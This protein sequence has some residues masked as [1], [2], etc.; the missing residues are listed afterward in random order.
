M[1]VT[2]YA[3]GV[4]LLE[5]SVQNYDWGSFHEIPA[6]L[7]DAP[8]GEPVAELWLGTHRLGPSSVVEPD[9]SSRLLSEVA[10]ELPFML[11]VLSARR[12]LSLQVHPGLELAR[13]GFE[14]ENAAGVPVNAPERSFRDPNHKPEM[15]YALSTFDMMAGFRPTAEILRVL[16]PIETSLARRLRERLTAEP[17]FAGIV[18]LVEWLVT[19]RPS[20]DEIEALSRACRDLLDQGVDIKRAYATALL[21]REEFPNDA[22]VVVALLMNRLTLQPGEAAFLGAGMLHAHLKGLCLEAMASSDNVLRAGL[23]TKH[24]DAEALV[25][26]LDDGMSRLARVTPVVTPAGVE[27]FD[28]AAGEFALSVAQT[29]AA[30]TGGVELFGDGHR[31][32]ICSAGEVACVNAR[33]E[34]VKLR[35]GQSLYAGPDDGALTVQGTGE[36]AQAFVPTSGQTN[37]LIDLI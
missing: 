6:F 28:P 4:L 16:A 22:G 14:A 10:G 19:E 36:T 29:S 20:A 1:A 35:R 37:T 25:R 5:N 34:R 8:S 7:G 26:C 23:T 18:Q 33:D 15:V 9:G 30:D 2:T 12:P 27:V 24:V 11:K 21:V 17:G 3:W 32:V 31:L 13:E